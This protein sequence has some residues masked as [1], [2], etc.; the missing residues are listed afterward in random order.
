VANAARLSAA[1]RS[2]LACSV[3]WGMS[4][5]CEDGT[6]RDRLLGTDNK[7]ALKVYND[8]EHRE[9]LGILRENFGEPDAT[10][11]LPK[12]GLL[13]SQWFLNATHPVGRKMWKA[14]SRLPPF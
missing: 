3:K 12:G 4:A 2:S 9:L 14:Q 13:A 8:P 11:F 5:P 10:Y 1:V 7:F 6:P